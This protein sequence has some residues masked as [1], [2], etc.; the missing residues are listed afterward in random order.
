M[1]ILSNQVDDRAVPQKS[2]DPDF[3][4]AVVPE[5]ARMSKGSLTMAWW[6]T[7]SA[8]IW[9]IVSATLAE[10]YGSVNAIIGLVLSTIVYG[11]INGVISGYAIKTG[12]SVG[13]FSRI[14]YGKVGEGLA[15]GIFLTIAI[16]YC[17]FEGS[18]IAVAIKEYFSS[19]ELWQAYLLV[20]I[21]SVPLVFGSIS[22]W[23]DKFNGVLLP[24][25]IIGICSA[26]G[27]AISNYGYSGAWLSLGPKDYPMASG[28]WSCFS[29]FMG[30]W[31]MMLYTWDYA[32]FGKK[33]DT[34]Y[35]SR[36]NFGI[37][38]YF[39]TYLINGMI[40]IFIVATIPTEGDT[41]EVSLVYA[42]LKL[43]G[44]WGLIFVW[45]SQTRI[46]TANFQLA[47]VNV[48][49]FVSAVTGSKL[50]KILAAVI[51]GAIVFGLMLTNVFSYILQALAYQ[52]IFVVAWV[53]IA[54][55]HISL[56]KSDIDPAQK[57]AKEGLPT[58]KLGGLAAWVSASV[59]GLVALNSDTGASQYAAA[60]TVLVAALVYWAFFKYETVQD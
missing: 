60:I 38:F 39:F 28:V 12:L 22:A 10:N 52:S 58:F 20:V 57:S 13:L 25:Y 23:L 27:L 6:A 49:G 48:Q 53:I 17:V 19:M 3:S 11:V 24:I 44:V 5:S 50:H 41:S 31:V 42:L 45:V 9:L 21:Y 7:C 59:I 56:D 34:K 33:E 47:T 40:G 14:V 8:M 55:V 36:F 37:P 26:V 1:A 16:Y 46:N 15:T 54:L 51:V 43:M 2:I 35:H 30:I 4:T 32:R 29:Y 18:V